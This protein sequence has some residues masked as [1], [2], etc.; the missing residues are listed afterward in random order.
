MAAKQKKIIDNNNP[1]YEQLG[2][3][4]SPSGQQLTSV[5][6]ML[7]QQKWVD[8]PKIEFLTER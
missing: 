1:T 7:A 2:T 6:L 4:V 8:Q 5:S 3:V